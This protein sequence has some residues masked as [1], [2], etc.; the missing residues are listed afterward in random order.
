MSSVQLFQRSNHGKGLYLCLCLSWPTLVIFLVDLSLYKNKTSVILFKLHFINSYIT[1]SHCCFKN[2][3]T[4]DL[5][6]A[7]CFPSGCFYYRSTYTAH[8]KEKHMKAI[9][10][11][12]RFSD[13]FTLI[14]YSFAF[15][16][17][18]FLIL[19][20]AMFVV[21]WFYSNKHVQEKT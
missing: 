21:Y 13:K 5:P 6:N 7:L 12:S 19:L 3:I 17:N 14:S 1:Y 4:F 20:E 15:L 2:N 10:W 9:C 8:L 11:P 16:V 18:H